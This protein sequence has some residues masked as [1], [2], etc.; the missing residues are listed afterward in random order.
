MVAEPRPPLSTP[1]F[2]HQ[3]NCGVHNRCRFRADKKEPGT[4]GAGEKPDEID[5]WTAGTVPP[6]RWNG[7]R[8]KGTVCLKKMLMV[9][10]FLILNVLL[11]AS[12]ALAE[13]STLGPGGL[14]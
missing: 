12:V 14:G 5:G 10:L 9:A 4:T 13:V 3:R 11:V 6:E 1:H 7:N 2:R 8:R